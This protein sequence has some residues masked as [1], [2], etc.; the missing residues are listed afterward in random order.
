MGG[1]EG[2][3]DVGIPPGYQLGHERGIGSGLPRVEAQVLQ[4]VHPGGQLG[5]PGP[6]R[7]H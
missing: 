1:P 3:V 4:Q 7:L 2:I 6:D 5:Q